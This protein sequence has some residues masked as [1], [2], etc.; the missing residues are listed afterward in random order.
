MAHPSVNLLTRI[1]SVELEGTEQASVAVTVGMLGRKAG[2]DS[3]WSLAGD[4]YRLELRLARED[5]EWRLIRA[6]TR[7]GG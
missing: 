6:A 3:D 7:G 4:I 5:G 1:E 2:D